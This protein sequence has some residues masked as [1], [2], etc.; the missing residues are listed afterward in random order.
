MYAGRSVM[1]ALT[2]RSRHSS[3]W[4]CGV[5]RP[6]VQVVPAA[7]EPAAPAWG[8]PRAARCPG[9]RIQSSADHL[10]QH[11]PVRA[12]CSIS[13]HQRHAPGRASASAA[14][15][16]SEKL[17]TRAGD[18]ARCQPKSRS[19]L[20]EPPLDQAAVPGR[21]L[22][23]DRHLD[24]AVV[25]GDRLEQLAQ[26]EHP[27][28]LG[29]ARRAPRRRG[30]PTGSSTTR[31]RARRARR[32]ASSTRCRVCA[33]VRR[34]SRS[35]THTRCPSAVS[36]TS[37]SSASAPVVE[38]REVGAQRVLGVVVAGTPVGD[39]LRPHGHPL[40]TPEART[41]REPPRIGWEPV[42]RP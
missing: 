34:R 38:G 17:I 1:T 28:E 18:P 15:R 12:S 36:R 9:P 30:R 22:G 13:M 35:C 23:L 24:P 42:S 32:G 41:C 27:A 26:G 16:C 37:H 4:A 7:R 20:D 31:S 39:D 5:H 11:R 3:S 40:W 29:V 2:P 19:M 25:V 10:P 8:A 21:V 14:A 33:A 6:H